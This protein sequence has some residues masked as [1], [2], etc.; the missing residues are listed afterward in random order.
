MITKNRQPCKFATGLQVGL[1]LF[2]Q[3]GFVYVV[4]SCK[5]KNYM[6]QSFTG[7]KILASQLTLQLIDKNIVAN[8]RK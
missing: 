1:V 5:H 6:R 7:S 3:S 2:T 4:H 8:S